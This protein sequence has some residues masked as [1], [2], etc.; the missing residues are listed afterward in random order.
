VPD[1]ILLVDRIPHAFYNGVTR[2]MR[3][4][5][6]QR[7]YAS[8]DL[9]LRILYWGFELSPERWLRLSRPRHLPQRLTRFNRQRLLVWG[10]RHTDAALL[11]FPA[12]DAPRQ[13]LATSQ[14]RILSVHGAAAQLAP[15]WDI[16][17]GRDARLRET[18]QAAKEH[19]VWFIT[20]SSF[21]RDEIVAYYDLPPERIHVI[22]HG[23]DSEM[24]HPLPDAAVNAF[25]Q[26][27]GL[28][29]P[30]VLYLGPCAPRKNVLRLVQA[31][32]RVKQREDIP[33]QLVIAGR[34]HP[35]Q[36]EVEAEIQAL[37]MGD[38]VRFL[39]VV[40][41]HDLPALYCGADVFAFV[42]LYEGFGIP[43]IESM[44]CG[45]PVMTSANSATAEVAGDAALLVT[46]PTQTDEIAEG[47]ARIITDMEYR[48]ALRERGFARAAGF[49]WARSA[50][51]HCALYRHVIE[52]YRK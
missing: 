36:A 24:F 10:Q 8:H 12:H 2:Y 21:A 7:V 11:H 20:F 27:H 49:T 39:G 15:E 40:A 28:T 41:D 13:W 33:H 47:L 42:S 31:F 52:L 17:S 34:Y 14:P 50:E 29:R 23:M 1:H 51:Q 22:Y 5:V 45:V 6:Q 32:A 26:R 4:L 48:R 43:V 38:E 30:Y 25:R 44:A 3:A 37:S 19:D 46:D 35:H 9:D 16:Q 18:M